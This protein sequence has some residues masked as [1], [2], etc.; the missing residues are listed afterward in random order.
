[1]AAQWDL[2]LST[3][4]AVLNWIHLLEEEEEEEEEE[5]EEEEKD[6]DD[7]ECGKDD[8]DHCD[9]D[10]D[11][12]NDDDEKLHLNLTES[13]IF[14]LLAII[15]DVNKLP[16]DQTDKD[17]DDDTDGTKKD[18]DD[19]PPMAIAIVAEENSNGFFKFSSPGG[20]RLV[21]SF[22]ALKRRNKLSIQSYSSSSSS[23]LPSSQ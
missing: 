4:G 23:S 8:D 2:R 11:D 1:M 13:K 22:V 3:Q 18:I 16:P 6:N 9:D 7:G 21:K 5:K 15:S 20:A 14:L 10:C 17:H 12:E 19:D